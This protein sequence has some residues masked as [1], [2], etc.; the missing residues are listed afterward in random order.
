M[1][2]VSVIKNECG[3]IV[4]YCSNMTEQEISNYIEQHPEYYCSVVEIGG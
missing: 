2:Y 1:E 3:E 4:R